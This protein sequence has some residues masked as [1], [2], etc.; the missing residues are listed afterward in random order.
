M[1][2]KPMQ[3]TLIV[4]ASH[5]GFTTRTRTCIDMLMANG[6]GVQVEMGCADIALARNMALSLAMKRIEESA[7]TDEYV[8]LSLD[9][10]MLVDLDTAAY[11]VRAA[12]DLQ[13]PVSAIYTT[14]KGHMAATRDPRDN[15]G[16]LTGLGC[17]AIPHTLMVCY[18]DM[19][20]P[21]THSGKSYFE[22][23]WTGRAPE[24]VQDK[25]GWFSEDYRLTWELG[26]AVLAKVGAG[27]L[28]EVDLWP[29]EETLEKF[30]ADIELPEPKESGLKLIATEFGYDLGQQCVWLEEGNDWGTIYYAPK[31][32]ALDHGCAK[33]ERGVT[34]GKRVQYLFRLKDNS[35][36]VGNLVEKRRQ[37][38]VNDHGKTY[39]VEQVRWFAEFD[40]NGSHV[41]TP[42]T[43]VGI[44]LREEELRADARK[45]TTNET[46]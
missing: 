6:A 17:V 45:E 39:Q 2:S 24:S 35:E 42:V 27:H 3:N 40:I 8:L 10:D 33:K 32:E 26:G 18:R 7:A 13:R 12:R 43:D 25:M 15:G 34:L 9:D 14:V 28:K 41:L 16:W 44:Y 37:T 19:C 4:V 21:F 20:Q 23:T 5:S 30:G 11:L 46:N 29:D 36:K 22:F 1:K 31:G 38:E